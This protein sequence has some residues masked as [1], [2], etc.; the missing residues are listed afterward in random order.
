MPVSCLKIKKLSTVSNRLIEFSK[1]VEPSLRKTRA[2]ELLK[3]VLCK[4]YRQ[5]NHAS[6]NGAKGLKIA[7]QRL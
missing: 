2:I 4:K 3:G 1:S 6:K 7:L 5:T